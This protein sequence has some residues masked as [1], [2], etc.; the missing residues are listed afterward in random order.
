MT[1]FVISALFAVVLAT[2]V[3]QPAAAVPAANPIALR[4]AANTVSDV[5][6]IHSY[7]YRYYR[8]HRHYYGPRYY[9]PYYYY[10]PRSYY[11][12]GPRYYRPYPYY[13][14]RHYYY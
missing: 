13:R 3:P 12:Y 1:R 9:R 14:H 8:G 4:T 11:Y 7:R 5:Q 10:G 6:D 2:S